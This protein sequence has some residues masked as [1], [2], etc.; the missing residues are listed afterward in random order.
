MKKRSFA[1]S[2]ATLSILSCTVPTEEEPKSG[3]VQIDELNS[4][5][6]IA[7][8]FEEPRQTRDEYS[9]KANMAH[10]SDY[11]FDDLSTSRA[12]DG[13][14]SIPVQG[15]TVF[16][17]QGIRIIA[18]SGPT[19]DPTTL[20]ITY[21]IKIE[22]DLE[23][24]TDLLDPTKKLTGMAYWR[25]DFIYPKGISAVHSFGFDGTEERSWESGI[26]KDSLGYEVSYNDPSLDNLLPGKSSLYFEVLEAPLAVGDIATLALKSVNEETHVQ[27]G[28]GTYFNALSGFSFNF[29][30]ALTH[31]N[32]ENPTSPYENY[33]YNQAEVS[34]TDPL[35]SDNNTFKKLNVLIEFHV[36]RDGDGYAD[37]YER[38]IT[39]TTEKGDLV[40]ISS[41]NALT[42][43]WNSNRIES[44]FT[45]EE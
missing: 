22:K 2:I 11:S 28:N 12:S 30:F 17:D 13:F 8:E 21:K 15:D 4:Y 42:R 37:P 25:G 7:Q 24:E 34:F 29:D 40:A 27:S 36:D 10:L 32:E 18:E 1:I 45:A 6:T 26:V 44:Y 41:G 5:L 31:R 23:N 38:D 19:F 35:I 20:N 33:K 14:S 39:L 3:V 43:E 9:S 16:Q